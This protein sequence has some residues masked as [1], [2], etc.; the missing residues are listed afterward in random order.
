ML[1][2]VVVLCLSLLACA[3]PTNRLLDGGADADADASVECT[4]DRDGDGICNEKDVCPDVADPT[5]LDLDHDHRG[6]PCD[7]VES[8]S[9]PALDTLD[10]PPRGW[11]SW[12]LASV[13]VPTSCVASSLCEH[14]FFAA[15][16]DGYVVAHS[17]ST[18]PAES[19]MKA[20][21][22]EGPVVTGDGQILLSRWQ[23][24]GG[25]TVAVDLA[26]KTAV[27]RANGVYESAIVD[28]GGRP[29]IM[30]MTRY[31]A[32]TRTLVEPRGSNELR[33]VATTPQRFVTPEFVG[34]RGDL[35]LAD[36]PYPLLAEEDG[37]APPAHHLRSFHPGSNDLTELSPVVTGLKLM[38]P[39]P[40]F[41]EFT[42]IANMN[43]WPTMRQPWCGQ[44]DADG[45][46]LYQSTSN[47]VQKLAV[48]MTYCFGFTSTMVGETQ[49]L[50]GNVDVNHDNTEHYAVAF[51][52]AGIV[53][54]VVVD[55]PYRLAR[56][57]GHDLIALTFT[58]TLPGAPTPVWAI[59]P[60]STTRLLASN[61]THVQV[62]VAGQVVHV[63]GLDEAAQQVVVIRYRVGSPPVSTPVVLFGSGGPWIVTTAEGG[64]IASSDGS[65]SI[66]PSSSLTFGPLEAMGAVT[67]GARGDKTILFSG[68]YGSEGLVPGGAFAYDEVAGQ[69]RLTR[70]TAL[71]DND[72]F[73]G[74]LID[75]P[76]GPPG[77]YFAFS[78]GTQ[79]CQIG[80]LRIAATGE[81]ALQTIACTA[82]A[83]E[84]GALGITRDGDVI[85]GNN[86]WHATPNDL[87]RL[88]P[89]GPELLTNTGRIYPIVDRS[90]VPSLIAGW[91]SLGS[92]SNPSVCLDEAPKRCWAVPGGAFPVDIAVENAAG[93][94][95]AKAAV[96][97]HQHVGANEQLTIV[98]TLGPGEPGL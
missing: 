46:S 71:P 7:P 28:G 41:K 27:V 47:G 42:P 39:V 78:G 19:W 21:R 23:G 76:V 9:L 15:G 2:G 32:G 85:A 50:A 25:D 1:R 98:R 16:A 75:P 5:Q 43:A 87:Y 13:V 22:F 60:D 52:R 6:W 55:V 72:P 63:V 94:G 8:F 67:G 95:P 31:D 45:A 69:P 81:P 33:V 54:P 73:F 70:L 61:L 53:R 66:A 3:S 58:P 92:G 65:M 37:G 4:G 57:H 59:L 90:F 79:P 18:D 29:I 56:I 97:L 93:P 48:P 89:N 68:S 49:L 34:T 80:R 44:T 96:L 64:A 17:D 20:S 14:A 86:R 51:V 30:Q 24:V 26:S 10:V 74:V 38:A 12:D 83:Y 11:V 36:D 77:E 35:H 62:S 40:T 82:A 88:G 91:V 84:Y